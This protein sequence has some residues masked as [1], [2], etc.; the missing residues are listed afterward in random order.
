MAL[1]LNLCAVPDQKLQAARPRR[2]VLRFY[3]VKGETIHLGIRVSDLPGDVGA[4]GHTRSHSA[5]AGRAVT[6]DVIGSLH[7]ANWTLGTLQVA[8]NN[9]GPAV[10]VCCWASPWLQTP[11][12]PHA[13]CCA[14]VPRK[15]TAKRTGSRTPLN[16][17]GDA[18]SVPGAYMM[19]TLR[20]QQ[21]TITM[22]LAFTGSLA[23]SA[24]SSTDN[25]IEK[26]ADRNGIGRET[27]S[28]AEMMV[29]NL[30]SYAWWLAVAVV[31]GLA[32]AGSVQIM[33][34]KNPKIV[35]FDKS[36]KTVAQ[37]NF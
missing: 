34:R 10:I 28:R 6:C 24:A 21:G 14:C 27:F 36:P 31:G 23:S 4:D 1:K 20:P 25:I 33:L 5:L 2:C 35:D 18:I 37:R 29:T 26:C 11:L 32:F 17:S 3:A 7:D 13:G 19:L 22:L 16:C 8:A 15:L 12:E 9:G 30:L